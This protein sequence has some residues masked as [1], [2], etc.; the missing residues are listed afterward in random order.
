MLIP[1]IQNA[2]KQCVQQSVL[3]SSFLRSSFFLWLSTKITNCCLTSCYPKKWNRISPE[4]HWY[5]TYIHKNALMPLRCTKSVYDISVSDWGQ[6]SH[7]KKS[8]TKH[9]CYMRY[10]ILKYLYTVKT[11]ETLLEASFTG[12]QADR[13]LS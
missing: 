4:N 5:V 11:L 2:L 8:V 13:Q 1:L 10:K 7:I 6:K 9:S 3:A 12:R